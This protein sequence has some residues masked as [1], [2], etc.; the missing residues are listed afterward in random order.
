M[1]QCEICGNISSINFK[2][3]N[4]YPNFIKKILKKIFHITFLDRFL[5]KYFVNFTNKIN[6][7]LGENLFLFKKIIFCKNLHLGFIYPKISKNLLDNFYENIYS[8]NRFETSTEHENF[9]SNDAKD[10][11][12]NIKKYLTNDREYK[13]R[14]FGIG[15]GYL[16]RFLNN[17]IKIK[18]YIAVDKNKNLENFL[19]KKIKNFYFVDDLKYISDNDSD[20]I[21]SIQSIEHVRDL[22]N[23]LKQI[24]SKLSKKSL[25]YLE[26]PNCNKNYFDL[27]Q[28]GFFPI[29]FFI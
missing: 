12:E 26:T 5:K 17:E 10:L 18:K 4:Y 22:D 11:Y 28:S 6:L 14:E 29:L 21:I 1:Y 20:L 13:I 3:F 7:Q 23:F 2:I 15:N 24:K 16:A 8:K 27:Y 19:A 9:K 25:F